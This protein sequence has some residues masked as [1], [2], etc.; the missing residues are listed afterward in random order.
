MSSVSI[1][2]PQRP[3]PSLLLAVKIQEL[4]MPVKT[5]RVLS[6]ACQFGLSMGL[7]LLLAGCGADSDRGAVSGTVTL[8]GKPVENG[9][10][11][12]VPIEGTQSPSAGAVIGNGTYEIP[13]DKG[14]MA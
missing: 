2:Q 9:S 12:F 7:M 1:K 13:R 6:R 14:P 11:S 10:I 8:D 4:S 3:R 5:P